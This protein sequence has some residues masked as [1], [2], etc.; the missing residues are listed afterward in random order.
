MMAE[1]FVPLS[2]KSG[3]SVYDFGTIVF[4]V[5]GQADNA[6]FNFASDV[7]MMNNAKTS[8]KA[9]SWSAALHVY[10]E[11]VTQEADCKNPGTKDTECSVFGKTNI[12]WPIQMEIL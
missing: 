5:N 9:A 11:K 12:F 2:T 7:L 4:N 3:V 10:T 6:E 8:I 1:N